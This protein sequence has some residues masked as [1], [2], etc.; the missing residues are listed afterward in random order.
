MQKKLR[1]IFMGT[2]DFSTPALKELTK[3]GHEIVGVYTQPPRRAGRG[4]NLQKSA[5]HLTAETLGLK[6][7]TPNNFK[8]EKDIKNFAA[9]NADIAIVVAYG[10]L[11]PQQILDAPKF[12]CLNLHGSLLPRW[13]GA[14]PI[15]RAIMQ[16]DEKTGVMIMQMD[17]GLDT[18]DIGL[19]KEIEITPNMNAQELHDKMKLLGANLLVEALEKLTAGTLNFVGQEKDGITYAKKIEKSEAKINWNQDAK[20][21]L[22]HIHGLSPFPGAWF[23]IE[24][25][26]KTTRVKIISA[27]LTNGA[28]KVGEIIDENF[29][30]MCKNY[31]IRPLKLQRQ[32]KSIVSVT[33]F[34][35]GTKSLK[36]KVIN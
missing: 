22:N 17:K 7:F 20:T 9:L 10:L 18:G 12:G 3:Q 33:D 4:K 6:V 8:D 21:I 14:A 30:I 2:P 11:L 25:N 24:L 27:E 13:R 1:I 26:N 31:A 32:G 28:G 16:G 29:S 36:N 15:Q 34:L 19:T 35:R 5:V 23:E